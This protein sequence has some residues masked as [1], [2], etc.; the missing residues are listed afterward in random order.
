MWFDSARVKDYLSDPFLASL[1]KEIEKCGSLRPAVVD[2]THKCNLR[3]KGCY[4]FAEK[5]DDFKPPQGDGEFDNFVF[6]EKTRGTNYMTVV[7]GEPALKL[8]R[9]KKLHDNFHILPYTNGA[10]PIPREGFE[11][12]NIAV[13]LWGGHDTDKALR[14]SDRDDI[15]AKS[16]INYK[17][18]PRAVWYYTTTP[19]NADEIL[20]VVDEIVANNNYIMFSFYEDH[21]N[22]GAK[23][24]HRNGFKDVNRE[25]G[26][27]IDKYPDRI[28]TTKYLAEVATT[29]KLYEQEWGHAVCPAVSADN[30]KNAERIKNGYVYSEHM[31]CYMP[32]LKTTRRC[33]VGEDHDCSSCFNV[34]ARLTWIAINQGLHLETKEEFERWLTTAYTFFVFTGF[35]Q[36]QHGAKTIAKIHERLGV[37]QLM[38]M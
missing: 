3:C 32:D 4:F 24:D 28:L 34:F 12:M 1:A 27:A 6:K 7:G 16:L 20:P 36:L 38:A 22:L 23:F 19:G 31:R 8:K 2:L 10:I 30:I 14:G 33:P 29:S 21:E 35:I 13:S 25:I 37:H 15:F 11:T 5:M 26:R 17:D 18:D 9:L